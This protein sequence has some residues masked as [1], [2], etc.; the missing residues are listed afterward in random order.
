MG[1]TVL[2]ILLGL[3]ANAPATSTTSPSSQ[4][5]IVWRRQAIEDVRAAAEH[6]EVEAQIELSE[7][8]AR[9]RDVPVNEAQ[10]L[11]WLG[12]AAQRGSADAQF[13]LAERLS[14]RD[15]EAA[16]GLLKKLA[17][18]REQRAQAKLAELS[19]SALKSLA[20]PLRLKACAVDKSQAG[21]LVRAEG[22]VVSVAEGKPLGLLVAPKLEVPVIPPGKGI[23]HLRPGVRTTVC[24]RLEEDGAIKGYVFDIPTPTVEVKHELKGGSTRRSRKEFTV[25]GTVRNSGVQP[26]KGVTLR[27]HVFQS[28]TE[29]SAEERVKV[30]DI[31]PGEMKEFSVEISLT[32]E[33][34]SRVAGP[35]K[36]QVTVEDV[37]W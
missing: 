35:S 16:V 25:V 26:I 1:E 17:R 20:M 32:G 14:S 30:A 3:L 8:Y 11:K 31:K 13:M 24:G 29:L 36:S 10:S 4:P 27:V 7:R 22:K 6:G 15:V 5:A 2:L 19:P 9:G 34:S 21:A 12:Q 28:H 33:R 18:Q 23:D 37:D